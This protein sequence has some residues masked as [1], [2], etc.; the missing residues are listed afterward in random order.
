M[1]GLDIEG[2]QRC[3]MKADDCMQRSAVPSGRQ[4]AREQTP[5]NER[6][7]SKYKHC[8]LEIHFL[9]AVLV[10]RA[11]IFLSSPVFGG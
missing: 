10:F 6:A 4:D 7:Q 9:F 8:C 1:I 3:Y 2:V 11:P 5:L